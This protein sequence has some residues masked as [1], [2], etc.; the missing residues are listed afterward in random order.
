MLSKLDGVLW[1]VSS[2]LYGSGARLLEALELQVK[3]IDFSRCEI[4]IRDGKGGKDRRT[5]LPR[6]LHEPLKRHLAEV[7]RQHEEDLARGLGRV[8][9]PTAISRK[10]PN[11][12]REWAWQRVFPATSHYRDSATGVR[13]RHYLHETVIQKAVAAA[14]REA[15]IER[16]VSPH[17]FRH[18]FATHLLDDGYD[19]R[20]VQE[21]LGHA[22]VRTTEI[23]THVLNKGARA[24]RS[25]LD[26]LNPPG[27]GTSPPSSRGR[28]PGGSGDI[29][30]RRA[31]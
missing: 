14:A 8:P 21:L 25:P 13:Y 7:R 26:A 17:I 9:L 20:T 5:M 10:F 3:D 11:A 28:E 6:S 24:V 23:Y 18:S 19:I 27:D 15:G 12:D 22:D 4:T 31:V 2:I 1:L 30:T 29:L 16:R